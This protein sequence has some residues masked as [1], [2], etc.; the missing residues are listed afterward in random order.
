MN[1]S[2]AV[3]FPKTT[4]QVLAQPPLWL[5]WA[6]YS[7][8]LPAHHLQFTL[9]ILPILLYLAGVLQKKKKSWALA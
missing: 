9:V 3:G 1:P 5:S 2:N 6:T 7:S 8:N 4:A